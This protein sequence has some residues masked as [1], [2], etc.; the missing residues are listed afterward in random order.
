MHVMK[1]FDLTGKVALITGGSRGLGEEMAV[2]L[3]E[4]GCKVAI[5]A[6]R[7]QGLNPVCEKIKSLGSECLA[8]KGDVSNQESVKQFVNEV[9]N[10]WGKIDILVNNAGIS[11]GAAPLEMPL[12][13]WKEVIDINLTG[14][15]LCCQEVGRGMLKQGSGVII[16][17]SS[18]G[19]LFALDPKV[20]QAIGYQSAKAGLIAITKQLAVEWASYGIRV[21]A[22][23]PFFFP[24]RMSKGL[25]ERG[26]DKLLSLVPMGRIGHENELKGAVVFLASDASSYITGQVL[27]VDGGATAW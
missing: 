20:M 19:G 11:W 6:R 16:N 14:S 1:L 9:I 26:S 15:F 24:T 10:K 13:K 18:T 27:I 23:A 3:G 17:I 2:G 25:I 4:A 5:T 7:D 21:N 12:D 8:L 22:I